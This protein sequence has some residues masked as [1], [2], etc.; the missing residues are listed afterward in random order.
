MAHK[1]K[2]FNDSDNSRSAYRW[3]KK[4]NLLTKADL[5]REEIKNNVDHQSKI[6]SLIESGEI[7]T[8]IKRGG[9]MVNVRKH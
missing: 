7:V 1:Q 9:N 6:K 5:E 8:K 4:N 2:S 3:R